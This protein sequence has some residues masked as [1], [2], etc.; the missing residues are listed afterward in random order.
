MLKKDAPHPAGRSGF[1]RRFQI[2]ALAV[3]AIIDIRLLWSVLAAVP[4]Y[5][6][7]KVASFHSVHKGMS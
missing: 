3:A 2:K 4:A 1:L 6:N 5:G 7:V